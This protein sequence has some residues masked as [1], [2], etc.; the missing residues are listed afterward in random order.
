MELIKDILKILYYTIN[1]YI[2][3]Y[4]LYYFV[5]S[6]FAFKKKTIIRRYK[7]KHKIAVLIA[8]RNE[9]KVIGNLIDSLKKQK[10][11][12]K[13][14][15][16]F[17][18]PN[19]CTDNTEEIAK[20][21][22]A[23]IIECTGVIKSKG[24]VLKQSFKYM[25]TM[26]NDYEAYCIF[27]ADNIVHNNFLNRMNDTLCSGYKVA[28][29]FR[30]TKNASNTWISSCYSLFYLTQNYFFNS[31]RMNMN[32]SA[33]ING[34]GFM[35]SKSVIDEFGFNTVTITEDIE[36]AAHCALNNV[37]I[38]FVDD[39]ITYDEQPL[40]FAQSWKQRTRW[41]IGTMQCLYKYSG[42]LMKTGIKQKIPQCIDM[43]LFFM[44]PVIQVLSLVVIGLFLLVGLMSI[45]VASASMIIFE[46]AGLF[47]IGGYFICVVVSLLVLKLQHKSI[48]KS[49]KG[50]FTLSIF[51]LSWIPINMI[52]LY[53]K[54][55]F[56]EPIEHVEDITIEELA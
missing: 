15:D 1:I 7:A 55:C 17:V 24:D 26:E 37:K 20:Q 42:K 45:K 36:F 43:S 53:R 38:A 39:A 33:S 4:G 32:W 54:D 22:G 18:I 2:L 35:I 50:V 41:S 34:T 40:T 14:Y 6:L 52:S 11:P 8:A 19:N 21:A 9:A 25:S 28:Q 47:L 56:W 31:A 48:K 16:I 49:L 3:L 46:N 51:M 27:D 30:D 12:D 5:T 23:K 44:A 10:Y 29:G 13:L